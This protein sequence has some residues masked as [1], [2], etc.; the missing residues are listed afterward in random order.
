MVQV[1]DFVL[2]ELKCAV[3]E[4]VAGGMPIHLA[5]A[6]NRLQLVSQLLAAGADLSALDN[7]AETAAIVAARARHKQM[8]SLLCW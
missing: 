8:V 2:V 7:N 5:A 1:L 4:P 6:G 3:N